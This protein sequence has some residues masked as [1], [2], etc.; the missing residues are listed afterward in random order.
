[1]VDRR[2]VVRA[3]CLGIALCVLAPLVRQADAGRVVALLLAHPSLGLALLSHLLAQAIDAAGWQR[4]LRR[5]QA[6]VPLARVLSVR[7]V[8]DAVGNTLGQVVSEAT[9]VHLLR[10]RAAP[11]A[12]LAALGAR[13]LALVLAHGA[14]LVA[15]GTL[16]AAA[17]RTASASLVGRP[18]IEWLV[19][20]VGLLLVALSGAAATRL[21]GGTAARRLVE[22]LT[23][24][25][26]A[27]LRAWTSRLAGG[28]R[29]VDH[30]LDRC[31]AGPF[32]HGLVLAATY[33][34]VMLVETF[35]T[36]FILDRLGAGLAFLD[37]LSFESVVSLA[38]ALAFL[39]P[40]GIGI[41][42][43][44]YLAFLSALGVPQAETVGAAFL[45]AKR[46]KELFWMVVG[47]IGLLAARRAARASGPAPALAT[48]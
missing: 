27:R 26:S 24:I 48:T 18:G 20:G 22:V 37:V 43:V 46:G 2:L 4:L 33:V 30:G 6:R 23:A 36:F 44:G 14:M 5:A 8:A 21:R 17:L 32:P 31:V 45:I 15:A 34:A 42:D 13:R 40:A 7:L 25:P 12:A 1:M 38:R 35:E 39:L 3:A 16:G 41:Q 9:A 19:A 10:G 29:A 28:A 47:W 11:E